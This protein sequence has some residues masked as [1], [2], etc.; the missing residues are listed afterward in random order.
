[1]AS[2]VQTANRE[3]WNSHKYGGE[4]KK[5]GLYICVWTA[6][7]CMFA[8]G[9]A[10][11]DSSKPEKKGA[12]ETEDGEKE[13]R[14]SRSD[15]GEV[16]IRFFFLPPLAPYSELFGDLDRSRK[17]VVDIIDLSDSSVIAEYS[18]LYQSDGENERVFLEDQFYILNWYTDRFN[19]KQ[20]SAYR[21]NVSVGQA[22]KIVG[23]VDLKVIGKAMDL[24]NI[25]T[26]TFVPL[27][28]GRVLQ[29]KF[30]IEKGELYNE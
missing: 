16:R 22:R 12:Y 14:Y 13:L 27:I 15:E 23:H 19:L 9:C 2:K 17:P 6:V 7:F 11:V 8:A 10:M 26:N 28:D 3:I 5:A 25:D 29:I 1:V 30:R 18:M 20:G 21:I 24:I 4:M